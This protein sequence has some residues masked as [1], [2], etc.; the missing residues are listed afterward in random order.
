VCAWIW[1][2]VTC[3]SCKYASNTYDPFMDLSLEITKAP[4]VYKAL[5]HFTQTEVLDGANKY[6]CSKCKKK[7]RCPYT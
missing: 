7:V 5:A 4:S 3:L 1:T 2:Q 6:Q